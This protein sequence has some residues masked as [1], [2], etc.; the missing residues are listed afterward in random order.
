MRSSTFTCYAILNLAFDSVTASVF[1][2]LDPYQ[3]AQL[4]R[5]SI[6]SLMKLINLRFWCL[7]NVT[8]PA[9]ELPCRRLFGTTNGVSLPQWKFLFS[10]TIQSYFISV[11]ARVFRSDIY[12]KQTLLKCSRKKRQDTFLPNSRTRPLSSVIDDR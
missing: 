5:S 12:T 9:N 3:H 6:R 11:I 1:K 8:S 7:Q 10:A 2:Q 4:S